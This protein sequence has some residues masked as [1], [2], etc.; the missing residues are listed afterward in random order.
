MGVAQHPMIQLSD[1]FT[2]LE[3]KVTWGAWRETDM[4]RFIVGDGVL[5][6]RAKGNAYA[7]SSPLTIRARD[8]SY[9]LQVSASIEGRSRA[10][11]CLEY[12][13][14]VAI[15]AELKSGELN[16]Y[17]PKEKLAN[18]KWETG[19]A[20]LKLVNR[21]NR[22]AVFVSREGQEWESLIADFDASGFDQ[23][24]QRGGFQAA[25][26][27]LAAYGVGSVGFRDFRYKLLEQP[28]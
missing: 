18:R 2:A 28:E 17:G 10:A 22:V 3:L 6:V 11:L 16:V 13:P 4:R 27:A 7:D 24:E 15:F 21:K 19:T 23:N 1:D 26:P 12:N 9:E 5:T 25:R 20:R 14:N 8:E